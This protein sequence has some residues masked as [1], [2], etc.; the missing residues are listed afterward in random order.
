MECCDLPYP[1]KPDPYF[2][3]SQLNFMSDVSICHRKRNKLSERDTL[4]IFISY[5]DSLLLSG[6]CLHTFRSLFPCDWEW[7]YKRCEEIWRIGKCK[8]IFWW[9]LHQF[10]S[11]FS[12]DFSTKAFN[13]TMWLKQL[14]LLIE[15]FHCRIK[16]L[17]GQRCV[18]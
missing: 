12:K 8:S 4:K 11:C 6:K 13:R 1:G 2:S 18:F 10:C 14:F 7:L 17:E 15:L 9:N 3:V 16:L 5:G